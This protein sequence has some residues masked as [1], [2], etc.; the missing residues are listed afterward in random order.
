MSADISRRSFVA[1][2]AALAGAATLPRFSHGF[3]AAGTDTVKVGL[4]GCGGRGT[5]AAIQALRAD[6]GTQLTAM[7]DVFKDRLDASL[8]NM[9]K[10]LGE[11]AAEKIQVSEDNQFVGFDSYK[12]VIDSGVDVVLITGYPAFR[13]EQIRAAIDAGKHVFAEKPLAVDAPGIRSCLESARKARERNLAL[14]VGFCWRHNAGMKATFER[15]NSGEIGDIVSVYTT[16]LTSTLPKRPR[17]PEWSDLE[18]QMRNWWHFTWISGDHIVEQAV[19]SIDRLAWAVGD[20]TPARV[21]CLGGRAARSGPE[22]G[23][24]YDHFSACFEYEDGMRAFHNTRQIDNCPHDNTDYVYGTRGSATVEGWRPIYNLKDRSGKELWKFKGK[25]DDMYQV[26]H[27][28]LFASIREGKPINDCERSANSCLMAIM[29]RMAAYT[30]K[31]V[32]W[33]EALNSTER[34]GP[35]TY[36]FS[37]PLDAPAI[38][39]PG[40]TKFL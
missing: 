28:E 29:A 24:S 10:E 4:I 1:S 5:G 40:Q 12:G 37:Q 35:E 25:I 31:T 6:A 3:F 26:E 30:G 34:L 27:N 18:F 23:N 22:S 16:Y 32:S 19:H 7:G 13:P 33:E 20:R 8:K 15:I 2:T 39:I 11:K 21:T 17:R 36:D 9:T 14:M 38:A